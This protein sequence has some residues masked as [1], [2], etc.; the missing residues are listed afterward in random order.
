MHIHL[1]FLGNLAA[2]L[3]ALMSGI[4]SFL[5]AVYETAKNR[6]LTAR[7]FWG[8]G[9]VCVLVA[10]DQ[11]WQDEHRN[12]EKVKSEKSAAV[13]ASNTCAQ[14][15]QIAQAYSRGLEGSN[16][17]VQDELDHEQG[18][19]SSQQSDISQ[20][21]I[22]LGKLNPKIREEIGI[23]VIPYGTVDP[24]GH[25][26]GPNAL[27]KTFLS[28]L[29]VTTNETELRFHGD[30]KC[31]N[32]FKIISV[33][34]VPGT[35]QT[36]MVIDA[37]PNPIS[38]SEYEISASTEGTDWSPAHPAYMQISSKDQSLGKCSFTPRP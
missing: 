6:S 34:H 16:R 26:I 1:L 11:A 38:E 2:H 31:D 35:S 15:A 5:I 10:A 4:A 23:T 32:A 24:D 18:L 27:L 25:F 28:V 14:N 29:L 12:T 8:I 7:W 21:V 3:V 30:L 33:P 36:A 20:C 19:I 22:S 37:A 17:S 9:L 13:A